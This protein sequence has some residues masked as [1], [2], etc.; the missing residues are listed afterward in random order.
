MNYRR[1]ICIFIIVLSGF[2]PLTAQTQRGKA[3]FYSKRATGARTA[4]GIRLHHDSMTCA[5]RTYPFGTMLRVRNLDNGKEVVVKVTDR[6]P[7]SRGR[8]IDLSWGAAKEL[9]ILSK[10]VTMVEVTRADSIIV[11]YKPDDKNELPEMDFGISQNEYKFAQQKKNDST[12]DNKKV[13]SKKRKSVK[14]RTPKHTKKRQKR[15][16]KRRRN[17]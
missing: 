12:I 4:S 6:G 15:T 10:G 1:S 2:T 13:V 17:K 16:K 8:I 14:K 7:F 11:P 9:G 3:T 5:H